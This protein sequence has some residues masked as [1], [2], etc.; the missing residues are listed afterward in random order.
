MHSPSLFLLLGDLLEHFGKVD[1]L[2]VLS[3]LV[4][5]LLFQLYPALVDALVMNESGG[6]RGGC[7]YIPGRAS[8]LP[9]AVAV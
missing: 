8:A 7:A 4:T 9:H 1:K 3:D 6:G 5:M 2:R